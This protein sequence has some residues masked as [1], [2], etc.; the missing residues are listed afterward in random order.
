MYPYSTNTQAI[1]SNEEDMWAPQQADNEYDPFPEYVYLGDSVKDGI[2]A[3]ISIGIDTAAS[4]DISVAATLTENG[5]VTSG[6]Q[7]GSG[8]GSALNGTMNGTMPSG[9]MPSGVIPSG[10]IPSGTTP[11]KL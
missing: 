5:G 4:Y 1:T 6:T 8:S 10:A 9:G 7:F 2:L 11:A 3:W